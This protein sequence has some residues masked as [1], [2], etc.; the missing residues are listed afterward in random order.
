MFKKSKLNSFYFEMQTQ[1][2]LINFA[3]NKRNKQNVRL[4]A[5]FSSD[6]YLNKIDNCWFHVCFLKILRNQ[7]HVMVVIINTRYES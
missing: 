1:H 5:K 4:P 3:V 7:H 6:E 2:L